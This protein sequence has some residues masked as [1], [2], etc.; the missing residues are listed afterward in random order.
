MKIKVYAKK[1][2][3]KWRWY[4]H[5]PCCS[6]ER[7]YIE[8]KTALTMARL[9]ASDY[10]SAVPESQSLYPYKPIKTVKAVN[11]WAEDFKDKGI[12]KS[13]SDS[14]F[15]NLKLQGRYPFLPDLLFGKAA[16]RPPILAYEAA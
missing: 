11:Q 1:I 2:N 3:G 8:H 9:H 7:L 5:C 12:R 13:P 10:H 15:E 14:S 6:I 16:V 4:F